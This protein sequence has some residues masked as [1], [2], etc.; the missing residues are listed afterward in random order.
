MHALGCET[1]VEAS[2][3]LGGQNLMLMQ[4]LSKASGVNIIVNTGL[5]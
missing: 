1:I 3:P 5:P 4:K 2:P